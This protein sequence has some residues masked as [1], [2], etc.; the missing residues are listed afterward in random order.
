MKIRLCIRY[1]IALVLLVIMYMLMMGC[2]DTTGSAGAVAVF[3]GNSRC[4]YCN[5][6]IT[7]DDINTLS[8]HGNGVCAP[9]IDYI[10]PAT[11]LCNYCGK[12]YVYNAQS[13]H[14]TNVCVYECAGTT[15]HRVPTDGDHSA[16][17]ICGGWLCVSMHG[18]GVCDTA[19][20]EPTA[21][22]TLKP[23]LKPTNSSKSNVLFNPVTVY[24]ENSSDNT[25]RIFTATFPNG[26]VFDMRTIEA[27][28]NIIVIAHK[29]VKINAVASDDKATVSGDI[30]KLDLK[31]G[32]NSFCVTVTAQD[33]TKAYFNFNIKVI[34]PEVISEPKSS[35]TPTSVPSPTPTPVSTPTPTPVPTPTKIVCPKCVNS[36]DNVSEHLM[37]C[38]HYSCDTDQSIPTEVVVHE[39][40]QCGESGH[41]WCD[42]N[43]HTLIEC[44][45]AEHYCGDGKKHLICAYCQ[46]AFCD[47]KHK[48]NTVCPDI[49]A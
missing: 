15:G 1:V 25:L 47:D 24:K 23:T 42:G 14:G 6:K 28:K 20:S 16:C 45:V 41:Y 35:K 2:T 27:R 29:N 33:G 5:A 10:D 19:A 40:G 4:R 37:A 3:D 17:G 26:K 39:P 31:L 32:E 48:G 38:G 34:K 46:G 36:V 9:A 21:E 13:S 43:D 30:G 18:D 8:K 12:P 49:S 11:H 22:P 44:G 7:N